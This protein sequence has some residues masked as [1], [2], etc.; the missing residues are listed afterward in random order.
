MKAFLIPLLLALASDT[1]AQSPSTA[2]QGAVWITPVLYVERITAPPEYARWYAATETC[3]GL[4]GDYAQVRWLVTPAPWM[5]VN[6]TTFG[7]WQKGHRITLNAPERMDSTL[8]MHEVMHDLLEVN[9]LNR[10][11]DPHPEAYFGP[12]RCVYRFHP[13]GP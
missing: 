12:D 1:A 5:G 4:K 7:M 13:G 11:D 9:G 10:P 8:V 2:L 6:G 3:A